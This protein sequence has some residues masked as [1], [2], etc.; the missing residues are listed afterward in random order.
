MANTVRRSP[1]RGRPQLV[2]VDSIIDAGVR[3]GLD[4]ITLTAVAKELGVDP[5]TL[6]RY[7]DGV[8]DL[9][10]RIVDR[11]VGRFEVPD[12]PDASP[13]ELLAEFALRM[14]R[15]QIEHPGLAAYSLV[16]SSSAIDAVGLQLVEQLNEMGLERVDGFALVSEVGTYTLAW[17]NAHQ[18]RLA[19]LRSGSTRWEP[20]PELQDLISE[21]SKRIADTPDERWFAWSSALQIKGLVESARNGTAPWSLAVRPS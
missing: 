15:L 10:I 2:D 11:I 1:K 3:V 6:Y 5:S 20:A 18:T 17:V 16:R 9:I 13:E 4:G 7:I 19:N 21:A 12:L 14:W 8:D